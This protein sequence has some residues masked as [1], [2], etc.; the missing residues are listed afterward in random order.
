M[1]KHIT[2]AEAVA[3]FSALV[4]EAEGGAEIT[5]LGSSVRQGR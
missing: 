2:L 1:R 4:S 3:Y 5:S